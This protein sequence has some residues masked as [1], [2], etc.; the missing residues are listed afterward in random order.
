MDLRHACVAIGEQDLVYC[1]DIVDAMVE[2]T[3]A[4]DCMGRVVLDFNKG[5]SS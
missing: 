5:D 4:H 3:D 2:P 1:K